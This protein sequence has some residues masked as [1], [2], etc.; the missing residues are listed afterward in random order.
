VQLKKDALLT[1][2]YYND[3]VPAGKDEQDI[4]IVHKVNNVWVELSNSEVNIHS[5]TVQAPIRFLGL[6]ALRITNEDPRVVNQE[7]VA[8]FEFSRD[9]FPGQLGIEPEEAS[10]Q[11][12]EEAVAEEAQQAEDA[13]AEEAGEDEEAG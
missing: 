4:V 11:Q 6:Y 7:P 9:P 3:D 8:S 2:A 1:I 5:N 13:A 12:A 10:R